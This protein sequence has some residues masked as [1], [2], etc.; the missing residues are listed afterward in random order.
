MKK[1]L[2]I[3]LTILLGAVGLGLGGVYLYVD[4]KIHEVGPLAEDVTVVVPRG[5]GVRAIGRALQEANVIHDERYFTLQARLSGAHKLLKAGEY[6]FVP[7]MNIPEILAHLSSNDTVVRSI[8]I[9]EGLTSREIVDLLYAEEALQ[10]DVSD[11]PEQGSVLPETYHYNLGDTREDILGRMRV[12]LDQSR[13]KLMQSARLQELPYKTWEEVLTLA[14]IVEKETAV[15]AERPQ[16]AS[17]FVNR[18]KK[19]MRLQSD[20]TVIY[21][22]T[23]GLKPLGRSLT[24]QDWKVNHPYN[25]YVVKGLPPGPIGNPGLDSIKAVLNPLQTDY[26]YFV[27]DGSGGHAFAK[28]LK[29]HNRNVAA[30]RKFKKQQQN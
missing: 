28:T 18:L 17:V 19:G 15:G 10:G 2:L 23:D 9:P 11:M 7:G 29:E 22:L 25:T 4:T 16:V 26:L 5:Q 24:R 21:A 3:L 30:W 1:K 8:T 6:K 12:S 14:S 27:A 20:P 13:A